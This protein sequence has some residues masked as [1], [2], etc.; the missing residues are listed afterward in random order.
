MGQ[1][2]GSILAYSKF[3]ASDGKKKGGWIESFGVNQYRFVN[4]K[5]LSINPLRPLSGVLK[6]KK[7]KKQKEQMAKKT[8]PQN[9]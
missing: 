1:D 2:R 8:V 5:Y 4:E 7:T 6:S 9:N 3:L